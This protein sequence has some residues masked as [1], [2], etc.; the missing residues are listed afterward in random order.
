[1]CSTIG[2]CVLIKLFGS[3]PSLDFLKNR[4]YGKTAPLQSCFY[5]KTSYLFKHI[6]GCITC[7]A[8]PVIG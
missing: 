4:R 6:F 3:Y 7:R 2:L 1:M 5:K 8:Y